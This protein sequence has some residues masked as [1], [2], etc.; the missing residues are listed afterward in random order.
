MLKGQ[1]Q[2]TRWWK[3][4]YNVQMSH[5]GFSFDKNFGVTISLKERIEPPLKSIVTHDWTIRHWVIRKIAEL[6]FQY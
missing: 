6:V 1:A 4:L 3:H 5:I 2:V